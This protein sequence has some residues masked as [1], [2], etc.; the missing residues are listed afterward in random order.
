MNS[1]AGRKLTDAHHAR[2]TKVLT[3]EIFE[4]LILF[5]AM[6]ILVDLFSHMEILRSVDVEK[7]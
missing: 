7:R 5:I 1:G 3:H 4:T 6:K 2:I